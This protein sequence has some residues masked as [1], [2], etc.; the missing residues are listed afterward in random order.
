V[1]HGS[2]VHLDGVDAVDPGLAIGVG[3]FGLP[4]KLGGVDAVGEGNDALDVLVVVGG[5]EAGHVLLYC[6]VDGGEPGAVC[7][8]NAELVHVE[9]GRRWLHWGE[10]SVPGG[11]SSAGH[12]RV[13]G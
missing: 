13:Q 8:G 1:H 9:Q 11:C 5:V 3:V 4:G 12:C 10:G 2:E 7:W 6:D